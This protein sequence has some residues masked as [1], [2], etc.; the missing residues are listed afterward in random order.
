VTIVEVTPQQIEVYETEAGKVPYS[1]WVLAL[2]DKQ[3]FARI[4]VQARPSRTWESG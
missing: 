3:A 2:K 1:E 4:S